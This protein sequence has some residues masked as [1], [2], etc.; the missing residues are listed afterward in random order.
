MIF[1][2]S[3]KMGSFNNVCFPIVSYT[4]EEQMELEKVLKDIRRISEEEEDNKKIN[5]ILLEKFI[6]DYGNL[7]EKLRICNK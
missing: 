2:T 1:M 5:Y 7:R 3:C 4:K 6:I